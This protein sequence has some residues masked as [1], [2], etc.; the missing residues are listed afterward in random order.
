MGTRQNCL[1]PVLNEQRICGN[2]VTIITLRET[3]IIRSLWRLLRPS[4]GWMAVAVALGAVSSLSEGIG[5]TLFI[6]VLN[7][8]GHASPPE[9]LP[10]AIRRLIPSGNR[11]VMFYVQLI[12]ALIVFKSVLTW[13]NR[14]LLAWVEGQTGHAL[15]RRIFNA[16]MRMGCA[17]WEKSDPGRILDTLANESWR[18]SQALQVLSGALLYSCTVAVFTVLLFLVSWRLT[19]IVVVGL[20]LISGLLRWTSRPAKRMGE[21]A[22]EVNAE[23]GA[24]MWD[25]VAG[26]RAIEAYSLQPLKEG[27][28]AE[29]SE[30]V[31]ASFLKLELLSG[32]VHP[33]SE[34]LHVALL[35]GILAWQLPSTGSVPATLVFLLLL[36]RLQP[37]ISLLH[38][39][40]VSLA[41]VAGPIEDVADLLNPADKPRI[42]SGTKPFAGLRDSIEFD[43]VTF[44]YEGEPKTALENVTLRIPAGQ[45]VAIAGSSG[46][47]KSTFASLLCRF[48]DPTEGSIRIDGQNL[49]ALDLESWRNRVALASQDTHL[50]STTVRENIAFGREGATDDE[51][52]DAAVGAGAHEFIRELPDG[53]ATTVGERGTR[54]SGGQRQRIALARA[55]IR[56]ADILILDEATNALDGI[57]EE[58]VMEALREF[59]RDRTVIVITHR[60]SMVR[61][62]EYAIVLEA[63]KVLEQGPPADLIKQGGRFAMLYRA[64]EF[65]ELAGP[66]TVCDTH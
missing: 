50:F 61:F 26:I 24:R 32:V 43:R 42:E 4:P 27:R 47:G 35:L 12:F 19:S 40:L 34:I 46:A 10:N 15:R 21:E 20:L 7:A 60:P 57:T 8:V 66:Q 37:N 22:V 65:R 64:H 11:G 29:A 52:I 36:F 5:I 39:S 14:A 30:R 51:V 18:A 58:T 6:P 2:N 16:L 45:V 28:F 3:Q 59:Q 13:S 9:G 48:F 56:N 62:A 63:G 53:Y 54:L 38:S 31:R 25:G 1:Q 33:S 41:G 17:F 55:L 44:R 23:L 49:K